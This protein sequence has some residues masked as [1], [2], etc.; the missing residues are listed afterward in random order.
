MSQVYKL[1]KNA[2][3][4]PSEQIVQCVGDSPIIQIQIT[5]IKALI[6]ELEVIAMF[7]VHSLNLSFSW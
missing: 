2:L 5:Q 3:M 4:Y 1:G 6:K 7:F